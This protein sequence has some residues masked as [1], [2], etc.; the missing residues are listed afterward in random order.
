M[1]IAEVSRFDLPGFSGT[2]IHPSHADYDGARRVY[3][4]MIDR[5]PAVIARCNSADDVVLALGLARQLWTDKRAIARGKK[6]QSAKAF[7]GGRGK[8]G[9]KYA[10]DALSTLDTL[11]PAL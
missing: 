9:R 4:G 2:L 1:S 5:R 8:V 11:R 7:A 10:G 6:R 3:N